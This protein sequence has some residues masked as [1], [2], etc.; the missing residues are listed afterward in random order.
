VDSLFARRRRQQ[1]SAVGEAFARQRRLFGEAV[2]DS[3][4][5]AASPKR[6]CRDP[7]IAAAV[8][9]PTDVSD[10]AVAQLRGAG[11]RFVEVQ[12][13][14]SGGRAGLRVGAGWCCA[15]LKARLAVALLAE[16]PA[17]APS[18]ALRVR[19]QTP[20][21]SSNSSAE[22]AAAGGEH[23]GVEEAFLWSWRALDDG[24]QVP[25]DDTLISAELQ[26][27]QQSKAV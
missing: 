4:T 3:D 1:V 20:S 26:I 22:G 6:I 13:P 14:R 8:E 17:G 5:T 7:R 9:H 19:V 16:F 27:P 12:L 18:I 15:D 24:E 23:G 11:G 25:A 10:S 2:G 21:S